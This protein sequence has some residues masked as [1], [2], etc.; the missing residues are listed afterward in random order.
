MSL[1]FGPIGFGTFSDFYVTY[2]VSVG[3]IAELVEISPQRVS[4]L[5]NS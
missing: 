5:A 1:S 3:D 2:G 4:Q